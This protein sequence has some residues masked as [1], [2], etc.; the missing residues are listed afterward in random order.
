MCH[1][2]DVLIAVL[3]RKAENSS[4]LVEMAVLLQPFDLDNQWK[5]VPPA[6]IY[7]VSARSS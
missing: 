3:V 4:H 2:A 1:E 5:P 6:E 7:L